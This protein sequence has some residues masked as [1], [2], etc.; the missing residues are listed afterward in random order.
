MNS[1]PELG[2]VMA[3]RAHT[4]RTT[5]ELP[6]QYAGPLSL[7]QP[8]LTFAEELLVMT[9]DYSRLLGKRVVMH[10]VSRDSDVD[11]RCMLVEQ[12]DGRVRVRVGERWDVDIYKEMIGSIEVD[13]GI[14]QVQLAGLFEI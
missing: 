3:G 2:R 7:L 11:L 13:A 5:L 4:K 9:T 8:A 6:R 10:I 14:P 1:L 12:Y